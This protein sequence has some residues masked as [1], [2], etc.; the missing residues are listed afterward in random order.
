MVY[1]IFIADFDFCF[2]LSYIF[3]KIYVLYLKLEVTLL[4]NE[5]VYLSVHSLWDLLYHWDLAE[6]WVKM[7]R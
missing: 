5:P 2:A 1:F 3:E 7:K 6:K 4:K